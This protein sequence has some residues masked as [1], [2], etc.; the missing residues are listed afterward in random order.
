MGDPAVAGRL[1]PRARFIVP[2]LPVLLASQPVAVLGPGSVV[3]TARPLVLQRPHLIAETPDRVRVFG[4]PAPVDNKA[5]SKEH[6]RH[7][8]HS[9]D[10]GNDQR[11]LHVLTTAFAAARIDSRSLYESETNVRGISSVDARPAT[12]PRHVGRAVCGWVRG[13]AGGGAGYGP[14]CLRHRSVRIVTAGSR[15]MV[16]F[17]GTRGLRR[18]YLAPV[19]RSIKNGANSLWVRD[20]QPVR[21][22]SPAST[23]R[24]GRRT[25]H[26]PLVPMAS[27]S[28]ERETAPEPPCPVPDI[29][30]MEAFVRW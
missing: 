10:R 16:T 20:V 1:S 25:R 3:F 14:R 5:T 6:V 26:G 28:G 18:P 13:R 17:N 22:R 2:A 7:G 21:Y 15:S 8:R 19:P 12:A 30:L 4:A 23:I 29:A 11:Q 9:P 27:S 24:A